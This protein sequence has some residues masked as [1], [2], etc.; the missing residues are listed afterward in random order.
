[1]QT[2]SRGTTLSNAFSGQMIGLALVISLGLGCADWHEFGHGPTNPHRTDA[3]GPIGGMTHGFELL[4]LPAGSFHGY[5]VGVLAD[6]SGA[7]YVTSYSSDIHVYDPSGSHQAVLILPSAGSRGG[8]YVLND[9]LRKKS[10]IF[11]GSAHGGF[12]S[13]EV[14]KNAMPY[15]MRLTGIDPAAGPSESPPKR[16]ADGTLYVA[17]LFGNIHSYHYDLVA[18]RLARLSTYSLGEPVSGAI[19]LYDLDPVAPGEEVLVATREGGFYVLDHSLSVELWSETT[20]HDYADEYYAGVT[21][22]QRDAAAPIALLPIAD[23]ASSPPSP[24]SGLLRAINLDTGEIE[25]ELHPSLTTLGDHEIPG[26]V[27][28]MHPFTSSGEATTGGAGLDPT[29]DLATFASTDGHLYAVDLASGLEVWAYAMSAAG[30]DA[31]VTDRHNVVYVGDGASILHALYG[32]TGEP[33]WTNS[34]L[35]DGGSEDVVKL[36]LSYYKELLAASRT[37]AYV[38]LP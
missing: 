22:A 11:T 3:P 5:E 33:F 34:M 28:L 35:S 8:P 2:R 21:V 29:S 25:W 16:A 27:S 17:D 9:F 38:L 20:G 36:G 37:F 32:P 4:P 13:I 24:N 6:S 14:D 19:A 1:M 7:Y 15:S 26:S 18:G 23:R 10:V 30:F 12:Y 31:P